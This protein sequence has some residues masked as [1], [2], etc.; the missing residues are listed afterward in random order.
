MKAFVTLLSTLTVLLLVGPAPTFGDEPDARK[1]I[2][3]LIFEG[4]QIIDYTGPYEVFGNAGCDVFTVAEKPGPL[5][6]NMGMTV[7]PKYTLADCPR[8][9]VVVLP[10]GNVRMT[11]ALR[12]WIPETVDRATIALS[13]CN[14]AFYLA[15]TGLLDGLTATTVSGRLDQ[16]Q[17]QAPKSKVVWDQRFVDNGKIITTAGLSSGIDGAL[18]VVER[19]YGK[20]FAQEVALGME[21]NWQPEAGYARAKLADMHLRKALAR[22]PELPPGVVMKVHSTQGDADHWEK[23]WEVRMKESGSELLRIV[24]AQLE[25]TWTRVPADPSGETTSNWKFTDRSG[26]NWKAHCKVDAVPDGAGSLR[27]AIQLDRAREQATDKR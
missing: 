13:V 25:K 15:N 27:L 22:R 18:H 19:L 7:T 26:A 12:R 5:K 10:G 1:K 16:L 9:D 11:P 24:D 8:P 2:A 3:I 20:G 17:K 4:V 23:V 6:T 14:G 21:Y